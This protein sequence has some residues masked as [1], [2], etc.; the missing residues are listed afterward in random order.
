[1][2]FVVLAPHIAELQLQATATTG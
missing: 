1:M 2:F